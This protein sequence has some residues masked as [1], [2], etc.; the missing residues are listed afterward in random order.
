MF[1]FLICL[2][3]ARL[4]M[5]RLSQS[6]QGGDLLVQRGQVLLDHVCQLGDF[7]RSVIEERFPLRHY[8]LRY[9]CLSNHGSAL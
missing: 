7:D 1:P 5:L 3:P 2:G 6:R 8:I 9:Q 4:R